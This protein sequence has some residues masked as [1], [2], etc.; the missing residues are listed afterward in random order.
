MNIDEAIIFAQ[1]PHISVTAP[2][3]YGGWCTDRPHTISWN[4]DLPSGTPLKIELTG[5]GAS[6]ITPLAYPHPLN[7]QQ[8]EFRLAGHCGG[9]L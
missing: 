5:T 8:R 3:L 1:S 9:R 6:G 2:P 4:S 7:P